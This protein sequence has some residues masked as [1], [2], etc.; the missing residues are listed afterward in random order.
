MTDFVTC[1]GTRK[2][3]EETAPRNRWSRAPRAAPRKLSRPHLCGGRRPRPERRRPRRNPRHSPTRCG[4][5]ISDHGR[6]SRGPQQ[7]AQRP[8]PAR[9]RPDDD[10]DGGAAPDRGRADGRRAADDPHD[11][12][13]GRDG[14]GRGAAA[15]RSCRTRSTIWDGFGTSGMDPTIS[16]AA[17]HA[18]GIDS[19]A[20]GPG[21]ERVWRLLHV[22]LSRIAAATRDM[23]R[24]VDPRPP[25]ADRSPGAVLPCRGRTCP[26]ATVDGGP[27]LV[28]ALATREGPGVAGRGVLSVGTVVH[29]E[30][31][32]PLS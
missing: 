29:I 2:P 25:T 10:A 7:A 30:P 31:T 1:T 16:D 8:G 19:D 14:R 12:G 24:A 32:K 23:R 5:T 3:A 6:G 15:V 17:R 9:A 26:V 28:S 11:D 27:R 20:R 18:R 21:G 4:A 13:R 22:K